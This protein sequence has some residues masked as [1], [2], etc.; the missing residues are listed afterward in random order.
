MR[1]AGA[2]LAGILAMLAGIGAT[3]DN[4]GTTGSSGSTPH[5]HDMTQRSEPLGPADGQAEATFAA[6]CFWHVEDVFLHTDGVVATEVGY[7]GGDVPDPTYEQVCSDATGHAE[8]VHV[9]Y[10]P[11]RVGY[12]HL[13]EVFWGLH[14]PTQVNRQ[15]PDVGRQYRSAIFY[16]TTE[17]E[18][19]ARASKRAMEASGRYDRP[20]AT[21]IVPAERFYP[22]EEYHQQYVRKR[23]G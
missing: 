6:G 10:D 4:Q 3:C 15:G 17:Q 16:H 22:A 2:I 14:D 12:E 8:A 5:M 20:I 13:L 18:R 9:I 11:E 1:L 19:A 23:G 21:Q 7:S